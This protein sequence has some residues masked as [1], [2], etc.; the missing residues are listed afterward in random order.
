MPEKP[1]GNWFRRMISPAL[2]PTPKAS[3]DTLPWADLQGL[4]LMFQ[5]TLAGTSEVIAPDFL[6]LVNAC[7]YRNPIVFACISNRM[8]LFSEARF[9]FRER[10]GGRPGRMYGNRDLAPLEKPWPGGTT[11]DLLAL[12]EVDVSIA[13]N[14]FIHMQPDQT[15]RRMRP[16]WT[17]IVLGS[18]QDPDVEWYDLAAVPIGYIYKPGGPGSGRD[19]EILNA[20]TVAHYAPLPDPLAPFRGMSWLTPLI[21]EIR[22]DKQS[23]SHKLKYFEGGGTPNMA[24][25]LDVKNAKE[26]EEYVAKFRETREGVLGN[27]YRTLFLAAGADVTVIGSN[28]Q[29]ADFSSVQSAGEVRIAAAAMVPPAIV[30]VSAGLQGSSL[31]AGNLQE[32]WR[33]FANGWARPAWRNLAG[34]FERIIVTPADSELWYDDRDIPALKED[35]K[36]AADIMQVHAQAVESFI[37][38]GYDPASVV[39]A[40]DTNDLTRL[41]H[42]GLVSVQ[43]L[44]PGTSNQGTPDPGAALTFST[45]SDLPQIMELL[46]AGWTTVSAA[47]A[48]PRKNGKAQKALIPA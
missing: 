28:L 20:D 43:L 18:D 29:E 21:E 17:G 40:V 25:K 32:V 16:D 8:A 27:P 3:V 12:A 10:R 24:V 44:P 33:Q 23:T 45:K 5:Q 41:K 19:I 35:D 14:C 1:K 4:E 6:S 37:R 47:E 48:D 30:S 22:A 42:T 2:A 9:Q 7:Y 31:N 38:A 13:G 46:E 15:L 36:K 39:D 26:F 11:G 34:S